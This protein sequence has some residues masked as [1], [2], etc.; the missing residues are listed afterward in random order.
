MAGRRGGDAQS[1][2][3]SR[4]ASPDFARDL[5][6]LLRGEL[7]ALA[8]LRIG[9]LIDREQGRR[10]IRHVE[11]RLVDRVALADV[12]VAIGKRLGRRTERRRDSLLDLLDADVVSDLE[13]I[14]D[15]ATRLT[16]R[17][18]RFVSALMGQDFMHGLFTDL[19][20]SA[21]ISFYRRADPL[22]GGLG[23]RM[24]E[25]Q[26][27]S[28]IR[29]FMP[30]VQERATA[31]IVRPDNQRVAAALARFALRQV[32][33][34][35]LAAWGEIGR[36]APRQQTALRR[37]ARN[38]DLSVL[39]REAAVALWDELYAAVANRRLGELLR[40]DREALWLAQRGVEMVLPL[41]ARP[42]VIAFIAAEAAASPAA[43]PAASA[44]TAPA[45]RRTKAA[46]AA[47]QRP[48]RRA[49]KRS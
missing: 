23:M 48:R 10:I 19:I 39:V 47:P 30:M 14:L 42:L 44:R 7:Q 1:Y 11:A 38:A 46:A 3:A 43:Q 29:S 15:E 2:W 8:E 31:F 36:A 41:L 32:L 6:E 27:K 26:I 21:L 17:A 5:G 45:R 16:P 33:G 22:F 28:F 4:L 9:D 34:L 13:G 49:A 20:Y 37:A 35:P 24:L 40:V 25:P 12:A 18:E